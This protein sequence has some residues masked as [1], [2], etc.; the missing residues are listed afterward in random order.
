MI[1]NFIKQQKENQSPHTHQIFKIL[2]NIKTSKHDDNDLNVS[3]VKNCINS[4]SIS[5][6]ESTSKSKAKSVPIIYFGGHGKK[7]SG[8]WIFG[9]K[10]IGIRKILQ[11]FQHNKSVESL[12]IICDCCHSGGFIQS[13]LKDK[14]TKTESNKFK[15]LILLT[16]CKSY[17]KSLWR[18]SFTKWLFDDK[19][20]KPITHPMLYINGKVAEIQTT[21]SILQ[22]IIDSL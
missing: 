4:L 11:Q 22:D 19:E 5:I 8:N 3:A 10:S 1:Q 17:Q 7:G 2:T 14:K 15:N 18:Y 20:P 12:I 6:K 21:R 16:S 9:N 13:L